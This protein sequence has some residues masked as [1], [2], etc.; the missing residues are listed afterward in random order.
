MELADVRAE[1]HPFP[2][3]DEQHHPVGQVG[4]QFQRERTAVDETVLVQQRSTVRQ[5]LVALVAGF[6]PGERKKVFLELKLIPKYQT[7][8]DILPIDWRSRSELDSKYNLGSKSYDK[9]GQ[10]SGQ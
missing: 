10:V 7:G 3:I 6:I 1:Q 2:R 8:K 4:F 9:T 5:Q